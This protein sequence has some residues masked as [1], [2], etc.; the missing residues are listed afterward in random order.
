MVAD[1]TCDVADIDEEI[2]ELRD[3][4]EDEVEYST[5]MYERAQ[6]AEAEL[7]TLRAD[8]AT[9]KVTHFTSSLTCPEEV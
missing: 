8:M 1:S 2:Q 6:L 3:Q 9:S 4:L 5:E 7:T